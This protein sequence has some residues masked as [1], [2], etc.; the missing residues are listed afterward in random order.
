MKM[1][2]IKKYVNLLI[3]TAVVVLVG[4]SLFAQGKDTSAIDT[5]TAYTLGKGTYKFS[6]LAYDEGG[7]EFKTFLGLHDI[8][9]LGVSLDI[10]HAIGK[11]EAGFNIP[12]VIGKVKFT[13]GSPSFPVAVALGYNSFYLGNEGFEHN[14]INELNEMI[15]GPFLVFTGAIYL[16]D[17]VQY[18]SGG[19]RIPTQPHYRL[20]NASY[21]AS[22]DIPMG[23]FFRFLIETERIYWN[24]RKNEDWLFNLGVKYNYFDR[25][26]FMVA[27]IFQAH[28]RPNRV[29]R[30]GYLSEF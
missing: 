1:E 26:S 13:E 15:Y 8:V 9:Y 21:F 5:P 11:Q 3:L 10:Q 12:G 2:N 14:E 18:L 17:S 16:F 28:E 23:D 30:L 24:F 7:V 19:L 20:N 27:M 4:T 29:F 6:F 22:L 25:I